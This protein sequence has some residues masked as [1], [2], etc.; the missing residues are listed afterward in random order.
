MGYLL[1]FI[2][3]FLS[4]SHFASGRSVCYLKFLPA[5][6]FTLSFALLDFLWV[7][8]DADSTRPLG[9]DTIDAV[10]KKRKLEHN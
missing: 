5:C 3:P 10:S 2:H 1:F 8:G 7:R 9:N 6:A 4:S